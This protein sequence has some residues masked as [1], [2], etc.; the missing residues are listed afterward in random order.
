MKEI[1]ETTFSL[2]AKTIIILLSVIVAL[3]SSLTTYAFTYG[4]FK[5]DQEAQKEIHLSLQKQLD[6]IKVNYKKYADMEVG[7][8]RS[9]WERDREEQNKRIEKLEK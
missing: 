5:R 7:G 3:G 1:Q 4:Y 9:D 6:E 2:R 8:L